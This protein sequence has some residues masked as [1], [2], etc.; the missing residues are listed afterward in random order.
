MDGD[1]ELDE[2]NFKKS[3]VEESFFFEMGTGKVLSLQI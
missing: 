1:S 3:T 2:T